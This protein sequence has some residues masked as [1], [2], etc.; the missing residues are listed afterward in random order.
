VQAASDY[1][2]AHLRAAPTQTLK[3]VAAAVAVVPESRMVLAAHRSAV[4]AQP[5]TTE[6]AVQQQQTPHRVAEAAAAQEHQVQAAQ[7]SFS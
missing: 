6:A 7:E 2:S 5:Q 4:Q 1:N 3:Q